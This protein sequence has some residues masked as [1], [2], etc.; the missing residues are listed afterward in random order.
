[1]IRTHSHAPQHQRHGTLTLYAFV[2]L[3]DITVLI[4]NESFGVA[5]ASR[6]GSLKFTVFWSL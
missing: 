3:N 2:H 4:L 1:M 5:R 6:S